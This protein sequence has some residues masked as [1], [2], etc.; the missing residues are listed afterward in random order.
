[1][2]KEIDLEF[3]VNFMNRKI[4]KSEENQ[5]QKSEQKI[6]KLNFNMLVPKATPSKA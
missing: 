3:E 1:M 6:P 4:D 2:G 5:D